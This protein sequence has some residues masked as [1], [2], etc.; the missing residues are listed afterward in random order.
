LWLD[1]DNAR[2]ATAK[3]STDYITRNEMKGA[4][5]PPHSPDVALSDFFPFGYVKRKW[6]GYLAESESELL[7]RICLI[8]AEIPQD[9]LNVVFSSGWTDCTNGWRPIETTSGEFKN[10]RAE[11][12]F[13][14]VDSSLLHL[15]WDT[16]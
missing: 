13:Y 15:V 3:V 5:H 11:H 8:L 14:S 9:V 12:P 16:L 6:M 10:I 7:V 4:P 1:V 2:R